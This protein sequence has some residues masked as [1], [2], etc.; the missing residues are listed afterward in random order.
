MATVQIPVLL[1]IPDSSGNAYA[2]AL[3][4]ASTNIRELIPAFTKDVDGD[5]WGMVRVPQDYSSA[6]TII[7]SLAANA[8][9][10]VTTV[11]V[12]T[13]PISNTASYD[14]ALTAETQVDVTV[15]ATAYVRKDQSFTL[16]T[17]PA[18]GD[19]LLVKVTHVGTATNDTLA[20]DTLMPACIFQ[21]TS[22]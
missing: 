3:T 5:W 8:T 15:P 13:K 6:A 10:G 4:G 21:Y 22:A 11:K 14:Q 19:D 12:S 2:A 18:A 1:T 9:T 7:L 17:T 16:S 20:V